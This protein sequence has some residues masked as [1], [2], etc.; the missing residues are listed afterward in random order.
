MTVPQP[1]TPLA[2]FQLFFSYELLLFFTEETNDYAHYVREE[3]RKKSSFPWSDVSVQDVA[4]Y[5]G[6]IMWM[7]IIKLPAMSMYWARNQTY[8]MPSFGRVMARRRFEAIGKYFHSFNR[9]AIPKNNTDRLIILR[10]VIDYV[11]DKC[12]S[13][14]VPDKNLSLD[15]GMMKW[16]GRLNIKVYNPNKPTKYG[17][18]FYFLCESQSGYV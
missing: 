8:S 15:E 5:L 3:L 13:I 10:P 7:G 18:K 12:V 16:K 11:R 4:R 6:I 14:Y 17:L 1:M 9:R 2:F